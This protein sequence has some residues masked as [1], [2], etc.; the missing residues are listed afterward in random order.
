MKTKDAAEVI[1]KL[2]LQ[3][4]IFGNPYSIIADKG[5]AF[6]SDVLN[7]YCK[8]NRTNLHLI[9]TGVPRGNGQVERINR[10]IIPMLAKMSNDDPTKWFRHTSR[11]QTILNS[12][13]TRSTGKTP[14]E[15][16]IGVEMRT[17]EDQELAEQLEEALRNDFMERLQELRKLAKENIVKLQEENRNNR[18]R[19]PTLKY[20]LGDLVAI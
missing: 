9:T 2:E 12:T 18:N 14:F 11:L 3:R 17:N 19:I 1:K 7:D 4:E 20:K 6:I 15:M 13:T 16:L 5:G 8:A 10:I